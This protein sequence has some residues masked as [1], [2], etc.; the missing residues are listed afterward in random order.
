MVNVSSRF[1]HG[2]R[3]NREP[4]SAE[5]G[6]APRHLLL[7]VKSFSKGT[8]IE[9]DG[10]SICRYAPTGIGTEFVDQLP[11]G[12]PW[13]V[14]RKVCTHFTASIQSRSAVSIFDIATQRAAY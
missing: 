8:L 9:G 10:A 3:V 6:E 12:L 13:S 7:T 14:T 11:D 5:E 2:D 1:A 4:A